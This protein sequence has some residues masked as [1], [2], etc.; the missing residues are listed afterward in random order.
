MDV[1]RVRQKYRRNVRLYDLV[2]R[3]PTARLRAQAIARLALRPGATVLDF[4]CG[5]GLSFAL[6]ELAVGARGRLVAV[7]VSP[8][9]LA[10]ARENVESSGWTNVALVEANV[11]EVDLEPRSLDAV[12]C[13]YTHDIMRSH[14]ALTRAVDALRP[15]GRFVAAGAKLARGPFGRLLLNFVTVAYSRP[16]ITNFTGFDR[17]WAILEQLVGPLDV[18]EH[19]CGS[20][21]LAYGLKATS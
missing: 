15:G 6:L 5:T 12:L 21:Y 11:E 8:E 7:D 17:P 2:L 14:A 3:R 16:A 1:E 9:M 18:E 19:L 10:R 13:F 4:G 20:A